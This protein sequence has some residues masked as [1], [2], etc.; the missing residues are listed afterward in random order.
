MSAVLYMIGLVL[1]FFGGLG[2]VTLPD[3]YLRL[4]AATKCG[5]TGTVTILVGLAVES[6]HPDTAIRLALIGLFLIVTAPLS[7]HILAVARL[8]ETKKGDQPQ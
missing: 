2:V 4:H 5:V 8:E 7:S 3:F 1:I 6:G